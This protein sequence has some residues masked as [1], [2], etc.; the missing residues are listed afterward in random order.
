MEGRPNVII[1]ILS[2]N[3]D[4]LNIAT[5]IFKDY[6]W[7][8]P[9]LMKYQDMTCENAFWKQLSEISDEWINCEMVGTLS[10]KSYTKIDLRIVD[11]II[12]SKDLWSSGYYHF[13]VS[14]I[15]ILDDDSH[16]HL[17]TIIRETSNI[18]KLDISGKCCF[19]NYWMCKP[20]LMVNFIKWVTKTLIPTVLLHYLCMEDA[21]YTNG[22]KAKET[23]E[24]WGLP[25]YP[26]LCFVLERLIPCYFE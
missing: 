14:E 10:W 8:R 12:K 13:Y 20:T 2:Y 15:N 18:L 17:Q 4:K 16:P 9:I 25:Y 7:A 6:Y 5:E 19:A 3:L 24:K 21:N 23:M 26:H 1:Y 11:A 22:L